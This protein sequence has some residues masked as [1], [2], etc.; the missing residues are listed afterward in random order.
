[1]PRPV[2]S[3]S[4]TALNSNDPYSLTPGEKALSDASDGAVSDPTNWNVM[5]YKH[6]HELTIY[7]EGHRY[8]TYHAVFGRSLDGGTK[9]WAGDRRT[10]EGVYEI[11][12]KRPNS[13][14]RYFLALN[15]PNDQ[16]RERYI[17]MRRERLIPVAGGRPLR[18]GSEIGIHGTDEPILNRGDVNWTTGCISVDNSAIEELRALLPIGTVVIIKP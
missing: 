18:E 6:S 11:I 4:P 10:P 3:P 9:E 15:Y 16:D 13:R 8:K 1:M 5:V 12:G 14:W 7:F 2:A 17:H